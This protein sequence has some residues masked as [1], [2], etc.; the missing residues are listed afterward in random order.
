MR[1]DGACSVQ[2]IKTCE[3]GCSNRVRNPQLYKGVLKWNLLIW[4]LQLVPV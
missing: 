1:P 2:G 3:C 4:E